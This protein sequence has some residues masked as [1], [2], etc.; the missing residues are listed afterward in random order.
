ME[1]RN[2]VPSSCNPPGLM[3][4]DAFMFERPLRSCR[5]LPGIT[6]FAMTSF[7]S[8]PKKV[9]LLKPLSGWPIVGNEGMNPHHNHVQLH[10]HSLLRASQLWDLLSANGKSHCERTFFWKL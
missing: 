3:G 9:H 8:G 5:S 4:P 7:R 6:I 2:V 10:S 1:Q